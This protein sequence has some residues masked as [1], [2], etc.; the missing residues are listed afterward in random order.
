MSINTNIDKFQC[1]KNTLLSIIDET[2]LITEQLDMN[3]AVIQ[4]Q[5]MKQRVNCDTFKV[6]VLGTFKNGKSTFINAI[7]G[8][9]ILPTCVTPCTAI[10]SEL[11]YGNKKR[12]ILHFSDQLPDILPS[13]IPDNIKNHINKYCNVNEI[14]PLEIPFNEIKSYITIT[15]SYE[16]NEVIFY[17]P[18][19]KIEIF[20]PLNILKNGFE[21][22]DSPGL[23]EAEMRTAATLD[24]IPN[25]DAV[26]F[27]LAADKL[28]AGNEIHFIESNF[29]NK[30]N[31]VFFVVNRFDTVRTQREREKL[32]KIAYCKLHKYTDREIFF[33]SSFQALKAK[34]NKI[35]QLMLSSGFTDFERY[36]VKFLVGD[37][38]KLK[39]LYPLK[40]IKNTII[41]RISE[42][43][44]YR[45]KVIATEL[46]ELISRYNSIA[47]QLDYL[48]K[49]KGNLERLMNLCLQQ[50]RTTFIDAVKY[51]YDG[52]TGCI[53]KWIDDFQP[54]S[55]FSL[56]NKRHE[57]NKFVTEISNHISQKINLFINIW[58]VKVF[59]PLIKDKTNYMYRTVNRSLTELFKELNEVQNIF[60]G[61]DNSKQ[62][63]DPLYWQKIADKVLNEV[64]VCDE[65]SVLLDRT[66]ERISNEFLDNM[67]L[68]FEAGFLR[69]VIMCLNPV[70]IV[71][72]LATTFLFDAFSIRTVT[73]SN[74]KEE[75]ARLF[76]ENICKQA[77][78]NAVKIAEAVT[79]QLEELIVIRVKEM[80]SAKINDLKKQTLSII[81]EK[82]KTKQN[83]VN[84]DNKWYNKKIA[85]L[86]AKVDSLALELR[87]R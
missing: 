21:L 13:Y 40:D 20:L 1:E 54:E 50:I 65:S 46:D 81:H 51:N 52:L 72:L 73:V 17:S 86:N 61:Y 18:Y 78:N 80:V 62:M 63:Q 12:V 53:R 6:M 45:S 33:V 85:L 66:R 30:K 35:N 19:K 49:Q 31:N 77:E 59:I 37:K 68:K 3:E 23:N 24:Y 16:P 79:D 75:V 48:Q 36:L 71:S 7:L 44:N 47:P 2:L 70:T 42:T 55:Q 28:C 5:R 26:L 38:G 60:I 84:C 11:K 27:I 4:L 29:R 43:V 41:P 10:I 76:I 8:E 69:A 56:R 58:R 32:K 39:L 15:E 57:I 83:A 67:S 25:V 74:V 82:K 64:V 34:K 87:S 14:P 9:E 22:I